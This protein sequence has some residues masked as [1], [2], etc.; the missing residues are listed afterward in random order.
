MTKWNPE[1]PDPPDDHY[2]IDFVGII[3][4]NGTWTVR[5]YYDDNLGVLTP[6]GIDTIVE[7][8]EK[9]SKWN[10]KAGIIEWD[11]CK[12]ILKDDHTEYDEG[13]WYKIG[14]APV[15]PKFRIYLNEGIEN[16]VW[17][18]GAL[19]LNGTKWDE[20][21]RVDNT[22]WTRVHEI[23]ILPMYDLF[24]DITVTE[25]IAEIRNNEIPT[26]SIVPYHPITIVSL[27]F[28]FASFLHVLFDQTCDTDD[29]TFPG[30]ATDADII[31]YDPDTADYTLDLSGVYIPTEQNDGTPIIPN[32]R[33]VNYFGG[34]I[35]A[36]PISFQ[37]MFA[38]ADEMFWFICKNFAIYP[39][40]EYDI[41]N[42]RFTLRF[43]QRY[44][45]GNAISFSQEPI[46]SSGRLTT[47]TYIKGVRVTQRVDTNA[48]VW[49]Y[50]GVEGGDPEGV[51]Q[52]SESLKF[53]IDMDVIFDGSQGAFIDEDISWW[54]L[55]AVGKNIGFSKTINRID[56]TW[57]PMGILRMALCYYLFN[58]Y[59]RTLANKYIMEYAGIKAIKSDIASHRYIQA[60]NYGT[61]DGQE[62]VITSLRQNPKTYT[63]EVEW[64]SI[65]IG[66]PT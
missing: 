31:Y 4:V 24:K 16:T 26:G 11:S 18:Y 37:D 15:K 6:P 47:E 40:L 32:P 3:D 8:G 65:H 45:N 29:I 55:T 51:N 5:V 41:T 20:P 22:E 9:K 13:F 17:F 48:F 7:I 42:E 35:G 1:D 49:N 64:L 2:F 46:K 58:F 28:V 61:I 54:I 36:D 43:I 50:A 38:D 39:I 59:R 33:T 19:A 12:L 21:Y 10:H 66:Q 44:Q 14:H 57:H 62:Y 52:P 27:K 23:E 53:D 34:A 56:D 30:V 60:G 63:T 25:W